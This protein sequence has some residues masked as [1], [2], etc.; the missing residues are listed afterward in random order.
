MLSRL[1]LENFRCHA[2]LDLT[3]LG[4]RNVLTG[5]NGRGKTSLL[6]A[7]FLISR[8]R[9]F[10]THRTR[11]CAGWGRSA[12]GIA[13]RLAEQVE[14]VVRLKY[15]W[16]RAGRQLSTDRDIG[17]KLKD[18]WGL[19]Q[20]V[21]ITNQDRQLVT[22]SGRHRRNWIDSLIAATDHEYLELSQKA[23]LLQRQ[24]NALL[25]REK[26]D[27]TLW[28]VLTEQMRPV[29]SQMVEARDA[30]TERIA[31]E[32]EAQYRLLTHQREHVGF[33]ANGETLKRLERDQD[34]LWLAEQ[35]SRNCEL[36]PHR[37]DWDLTLADKPLR[38]FGSEGQQ[39]SAALAM[40]L[41][42]LKL[43][44]AA[45]PD[46]TVVLIDDALIELDTGRRQRFWQQV[47]ENVQVMYAT[48]DADRDAEF[49]NFERAWQVEPGN[50]GIK[51]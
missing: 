30:M 42:E 14:G 36:G 44:A 46:R 25:K 5:A 27:R 49:T 41:A 29:C 50:V 16:T 47:P 45:N 17:I 20:A 11:E 32:I 26:T 18:F 34:E 6:E 7:V 28:T 8:C 51:P 22:E 10:R 37:D 48:T 31:P 35:K 12:F 43:D 3:E 23:L 24:K 4:Q 40:R 21:A 1:I 13:G 38:H 39:K 33:T 9:S 19:L 2:Q 15:E